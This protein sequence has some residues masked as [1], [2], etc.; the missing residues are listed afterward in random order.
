MAVWLL[1]GDQYTAFSSIVISAA[2]PKVMDPNV[3]VNT[4]YYNAYKATQEQKLLSRQ[5]IEQG[6][7]GQAI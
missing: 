1:I 2:D 3:S 7:A 6:P 4:D 5:V